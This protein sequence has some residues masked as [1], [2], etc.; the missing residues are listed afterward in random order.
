MTR[1]QAL[2]DLFLSVKKDL[3]NKGVSEKQLLKYLNEFG[4][5]LL[6]IET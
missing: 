2:E 5:K 3:L 1:R 6:I 4:I